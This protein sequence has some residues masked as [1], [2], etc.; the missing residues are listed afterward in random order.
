MA[1]VT[2]NAAA[3]NPFLRFFSANMPKPVQI[4]WAV[5]L[6]QEIL[7]RPTNKLQAERWGQLLQGVSGEKLAAAFFQ[8]A[9]TV[10]D[11]PRPAD[12]LDPIL[13]DECALDLDWLL[14]GLR[15]HGWRWEGRDAL[16]GDRW[17]KPGAGIDEWE[18][19]PI[20][21]PAIPA[22]EIPQ[23]L[24]QV[25]RRLGASTEADGL[26]V[27]CH[28]PGAHNEPLQGEDMLKVKRQIEWD[29]KQAWMAVRK[30]ELSEGL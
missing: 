21:E 28:H 8:A 10:R 27:L 7:D 29:F 30:R 2:K 5:L 12:I 19:A 26:R 4:E 14:S 17:R 6:L 18:P 25:L 1:M 15:R 24:R 23:R 16:Y 3:E 13:D 22:P 9:V 11:W 20:I